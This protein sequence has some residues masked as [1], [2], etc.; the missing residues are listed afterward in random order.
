M[1]YWIGLGAFLM[2]SAVILGAVGSHFFASSLEATN[3]KE[4]FS[5]LISTLWYMP[6]E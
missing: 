3:S 2:A 1:K 4:T 6:W 5:G